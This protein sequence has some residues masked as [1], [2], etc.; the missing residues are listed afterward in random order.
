MVIF[1]AL[2]GGVA[3]RRGFDQ[4]VLRPAI[5]AA[6]QQSLK[7]SPDGS[8]S[9]RDLARLVQQ[10]YEARD[11]RLAWD[12]DGDVKGAVGVLQASASHGLAELARYLLSTEGAEWTVEK[13]A[14]TVKTN[15]ESHIAD[16]S[17]QPRYLADVYGFDRKQ[18]SAQ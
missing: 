1:G 7:A 10:W 5:D 11:Y 3:C 16:G 6:V 13:I 18:M 14:D 9:D 8:R 2:T 4:S 17:G 15:E 12:D